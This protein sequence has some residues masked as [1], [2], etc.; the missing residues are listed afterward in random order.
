MVQLSPEV[1]IYCFGAVSAAPRSMLPDR[2]RRTRL[3]TLESELLAPVF[4]FFG[5]RAEPAVIN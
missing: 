1:A 5:A 4:A 3:L 2:D